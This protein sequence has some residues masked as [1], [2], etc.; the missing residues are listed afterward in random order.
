ML[1]QQHFEHWSYIE[2]LLHTMA[3]QM[4]LTSQG[5]TNTDDLDFDSTWGV[6][7]SSL[8]EIHTKNA[9]ELSFEQLYRN[10]YKLVLKKKGEALYEKVKEFE[11]D[12]LLS[13]V[14]P[15][16]LAVL[17][18]SLFT[19]HVDAVAATNANEKRIAGD[20]L[21][22]ALKKAWQDHNLCMNMTTDVLMYMVRQ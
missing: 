3:N 11:R 4:L 21:M 20:R 17:S 8:R 1:T 10:A 2:P 6:L 12:W 14:Q 15:Q 9:S 7:A 22:R 16:I 18:A 19:G 5:L 13:E